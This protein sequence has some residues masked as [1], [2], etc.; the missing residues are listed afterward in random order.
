MWL[1]RAPACA[2]HNVPAGLVTLI[3]RPRADPSLHSTYHVNFV[4]FEAESCIRQEYP[5]PTRNCSHTARP[6]GCQ[7][8]ALINGNADWPPS[9][10][11]TH[12]HPRGPSRTPRPKDWADGS[13][14]ASHRFGFVHW[15]LACP[16]L[17]CEPICAGRG[18]IRQ[19]A[20]VERRHRRIGWRRGPT[21]AP[22]GPRTSANRMRFELSPSVSR[23]KESIDATNPA[24]PSTT[25]DLDR[26]PG[27]NQQA[28]S[29]QAHSIV[30][31]QIPISLRSDRDNEKRRYWRWG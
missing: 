9:M 28:R 27:E 15:R 17:T 3:C 30:K 18:P 31:K 22:R 14:A 26:L 11:I 21:P 16:E 23:S 8:T 10:R 29:S 19:P 2:P 6:A 1:V 13:T 4:P 7:S 12:V 5:R 20:P 24:F 25:H